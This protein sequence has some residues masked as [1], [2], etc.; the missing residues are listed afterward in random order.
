MG[1]KADKQTDPDSNSGKSKLDKPIC[2]M[3][4]TLGATV[5][6][7]TPKHTL[8]AQY[9]HQ[10][11]KD[12]PYH[13]CEN[14]DCD[15]VYFNCVSEKHYKKKQLSNRV[16]IKDEHPKTPLC[17]CFNVL[18]ED[19]LKELDETGNSDVVAMIKKSMKN[20]GCRCE[21]L[22]PRGGCCIKD[23]EKWLFTLRKQRLTTPGNG[24]Q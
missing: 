15:V 7:I 13:F 10:I 16:T 3:C 21:K 12:G 5:K 9:S 2:P 1:I 23:I 22:N 4:D 8:K 18:K 20:H 24:I 19:A 11:D 14:P 6:P 17:Y